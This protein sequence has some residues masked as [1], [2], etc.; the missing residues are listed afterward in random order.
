MAVMAAVAAP[1]YEGLDLGEALHRGLGERRRAVVIG[2][3]S[4]K[5]QS[6]GVDWFATRSER[7]LRSNILSSARRGV[8]NFHR[9][10]GSN[11]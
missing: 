6:V 10:S 8:S 11:I 5:F 4:F 9:R 2:P 3:Q 7:A 1:R